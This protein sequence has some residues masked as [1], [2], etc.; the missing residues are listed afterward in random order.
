VDESLPL[1]AVQRVDDVCDQF[2]AALKEGGRPRIEDYLGAA[3]G[4]ERRALLCELVLVELE[5]RYRRGESPTPGEYGE[6]IDSGFASMRKGGSGQ[7]QLDSTPLQ[8]PY[9]G[10]CAG[11]RAGAARTG[12]AAADGVP[13]WAGRFRIEADISNDTGG[14]GDV[15]RVC[16]DR[17]NRTLAVKVLK[18]RFRGNGEMIARILL[19][20]EITGQL[21]HPA[22][23]PIHELGEM[24]DGRPFFAMKLIEGLTLA[25]LLAARENV[26]ASLQLADEERQVANLPARSDL[27][28]WLGVFEHICQAVSFAHSKGVIHRDLKP[29]NVMVGAF[30]EVQVMD[31]GLA[32]RLAVDD[33]AAS[34]TLGEREEDPLAPLLQPASATGSVSRNGLTWP[35]DVLGTPAY[36]PPEQAKGAWGQAD[37]RVDVFALGS[38]LCEILTGKPA[39]VGGARLQLEHKARHGDLAEAFA[40]LEGC[41]ADAELL[42]LAR[43]CL[44][45]DKAERPR[46]AGV[47]A[48]TMRLYLA[49][50]QERL[51]AAEVKQAAAQARAEEA[52]KK[53][54]AERRARNRN[55]MRRRPE[56]RR[57]QLGQQQ[58]DGRGG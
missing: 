34:P 29:R 27:P 15:F 24:A 36:M 48:E 12:P 55:A 8:C 54:A 17:L 28:R 25:D 41:G 32:K 20:A 5:Y 49:G 42:Q 14:M 56:P 4:E 44:A 19:E 47:V 35:G 50:V 51:R 45:P 58:S 9:G 38:I 10:P 3:A 16:D 40:R 18:K 1:S 26:P 53:A 6:L 11:Q 57:R 39:Y 13:V 37:E 30:G 23:P 2:E 46:H 31:W 33:S 22:I 43:R 52:V 7:K 21:Q